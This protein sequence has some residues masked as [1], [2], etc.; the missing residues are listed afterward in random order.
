MEQDRSQA[1][2]NQVYYDIMRKK[3]H[4]KKFEHKVFTIGDKVLLSIKDRYVGNNLKLQQLF[5][6][7]FKIIDQIHD[8]TY[9]IKRIHPVEGKKLVTVAHVS[10]LKLYRERSDEDIILQPRSDES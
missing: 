5:D 4:D 7:P 9:K 2:T 3:A 6:G 8:V 1:T 10:K